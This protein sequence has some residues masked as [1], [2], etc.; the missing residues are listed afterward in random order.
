MM[1]VEI[2]QWRAT[3]G[4][5]RVSIQISSPLSK[6]P[7]PLCVLVHI[8]KLYW[9]C[10]CFI[11]VSIIVLPLTLMIHFL[12]VHSVATQLRL[13]PLFARI[14][15]LVKIVIYTTVELFK[16]I[17][18]LIIGLTHCKRLAVKQ[19]IF[20]YAYFYTGCIACY[21]F[22]AQWL[23]FRAI[24]LSGDVEK[25]PGPE[26]L[27]FCTWNLNS[28]SAHDFLLVSLIEA[29]N[30]VYNYDLIGIVEPHHD[31]LALDGYSFIK[32][33]HPQNVKRGGV[34]LYVKDSLA[35]KIV[36]IS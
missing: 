33:N 19:F 35:S 21:T 23:V 17:P 26:T 30:S 25:N 12:A 28:I 18:R 8:L 11:A 15:H 31:R 4:C 13:M 3:I 1:L 5:F 22:H 24:L 27:N 14:H 9:I 7:R 6:S 10:C 16:R 29:Y 32:S 36:L 34:G 20:L 2:N